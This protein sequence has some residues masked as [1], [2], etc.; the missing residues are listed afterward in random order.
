MPTQTD[1]YEQSTGPKASGCLSVH[2]VVLDESKCTDFRIGDLFVDVMVVGTR[3]YYQDP[4]TSPYAISGLVCTINNEYSFDFKN[5]FVLKEVVVST[6]AGKHFADFQWSIVSY[7]KSC[8]HLSIT[9][10]L[11]INVQQDKALTVSIVATVLAPETETK[12][13]KFVFNG[14]THW[15]VPFYGS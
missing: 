12:E 9:P 4:Q 15:Y 1:V 13:M 7:N 11:D 8:R 10:W 3:E 6:G 5:N 2:D 14:E